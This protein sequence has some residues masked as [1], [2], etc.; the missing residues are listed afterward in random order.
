MTM[1]SDQTPTQYIPFKV[2][3]KHC[4]MITS[5]I[6]WPFN[7]KNPSLATHHLFQVT[8]NLISQIVWTLL[9]TVGV[10]DINGSQNR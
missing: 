5:Q 2:V 1:V 10:K 3:R 9:N 8:R 7:L 4:A 6:P